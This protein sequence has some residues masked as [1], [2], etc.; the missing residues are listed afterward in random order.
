M[1]NEFGCV[2]TACASRGRDDVLMV[3]LVSLTFG[4]VADWLTAVPRGLSSTFSS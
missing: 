2:I 1:S 3:I 4:H